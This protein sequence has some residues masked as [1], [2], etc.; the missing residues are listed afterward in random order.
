MIDLTPVIIST[1]RSKGNRIE[2]AIRNGADGARDV[3]LHMNPK[4]GFLD[5]QH[6]YHVKGHEFVVDSTAADLDPHCKK[7]S[8]FDFRLTGPDTGD[9]TTRATRVVSTYKTDT[10]EIGGVGPAPADAEEQQVGSRALRSRAPMR[11]VRS[12][13]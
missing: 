12:S 6:K 8:R 13:A 7:P 11:A 2:I 9:R 4:M 1:V 5:P 3:V 10:P